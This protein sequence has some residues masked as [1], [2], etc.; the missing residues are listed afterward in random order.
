MKM[1]Q[2]HKDKIGRAIKRAWQNPE[3]R[4]KKIENLR[5]HT[6]S[7]ETRKKISKSLTKK[8]LP[9]C[10]VCGKKLGDWRSKH[11]VSC[12]GNLQSGKNNPCWKGEKAK[13]SKLALLRGTPQSLAWRLSVYRRDKF[14]CQGCCEVGGTLN[15]HHILPFAKYP[16]MRF[17]VKNGVTLCEK[18]HKELHGLIK[19]KESA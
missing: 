5:G 18:C 12:N 14:T 8:G 3:Y 4:E 1:T 16:E 6:V 10:L 19:K 17:E 13:S 15:A 7:K 2:E 11:C 9:H